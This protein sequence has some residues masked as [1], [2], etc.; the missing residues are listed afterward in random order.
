[1]SWNSVTMYSE[2]DIVPR[3]SPSLASLMTSAFGEIDK[4]ITDR[5]IKVGIRL[6][7]AWESLSTLFPSALLNPV[8]GASL[9]GT[10]DLPLVITGR[11]GDR[12]TVVNAQI[13]KLADLFLGVDSSLFAADVEFTGI[14]A[15]GANPE[16]A[17]SY[18][19]TATAQTYTEAFAKTNFK[20]QR[21]T[22]AWGAKTG[23][24]AIV[25]QL[26]V[27]IAW[28]LNLA[29][30]R[31][32]GLGT[33]DMTVKDMVGSAKCVPIGPTMAQIK[34]EGVFETALGTLQGANAADLV[35]TGSGGSPVITLKNAALGENGLAFGIEPLRNGELA[36]NTTRGFSAGAAVAVATVG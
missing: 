12:I 23:W 19:S 3:F 30:L 10:T 5:M 36:W 21:F 29:P 27:N 4:V 6:W 25:P 8:A 15:G 31:V 18:F 20:R 34:T 32:T 7:G 14:L 24:T 17:S 1:M 16:D 22:G 9:Y 2:G 11:N 26:G 33:V 35:W 28:N 13:T